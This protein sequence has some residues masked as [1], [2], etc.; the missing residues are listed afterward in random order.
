MKEIK[1]N[2]SLSAI[3]PRQ[4][5]DILDRGDMLLQLWRK[6]EVEIRLGAHLES[7]FKISCASPF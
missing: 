4:L 1:S 7:G 5:W 3:E 2:F 6:W